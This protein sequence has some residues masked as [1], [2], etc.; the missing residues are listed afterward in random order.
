[1]PLFAMFARMICIIESGNEN[2]IYLSIMNIQ[3]DN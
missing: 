1:M 2:K 3:E